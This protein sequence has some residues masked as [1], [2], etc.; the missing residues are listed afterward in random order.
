MNDRTKAILI[1]NPANPVGS[2]FT[3]EHIREIIAVAD[4]LKIPII[5]DEVYY[6]M[7]YDPE[8][9]FVSFGNSTSTVPIIC[10][11]ALSKAYSLPGWRLGWTIV[12]NHQG[13]F[14]DVLGRLAKHSMIQL[15]PNSLVQHAL[16][17]ILKEVPDSYFEGVRQRLAASSEAAFTRLQAIR[18]VT[19]I[20]SSAAMYMMVRIDFDEFK[21]FESDVD[22]CSKFLQEQN[23]LTYPSKCFFMPGFFRM[24]ICTS[25]EVIA[26]FGDRL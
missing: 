14:D 6:G 9:P 4:E 26:D 22:F 16:P 7:S 8:R 21:D 15:H 25:L 1:N 19:P 11:G 2:C 23:V 20:K 5:A 24:I 13:Y 18:G 12:Y 3:A 10:T 17:R